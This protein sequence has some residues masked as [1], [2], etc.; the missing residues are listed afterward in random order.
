MQR[1]SLFL[2]LTLVV[3][4]LLNQACTP[5][6]S[7]E[8]TIREAGIPV[9]VMDLK[10][11]IWNPPIHTSGRFA[12]EDENVLAFKTG[13]II[14]NIYVRE[15]EAIKRGQ[16]LAKLNLTEISALTSQAE[17][18]FEK[19][20]R[21]Y[22][23]AE[24]LFAD[25]VA[26]LEQLQNSRTALDIA[27]QQLEQANFN[28]SHSEIRAP[29][30][31]YVLQKM[32]SSGQVMAGGMPVL[33]TSGGANTDWVLKT[34]LSDK[35]WAQIQVGDS[36]EILSTSLSEN[37]IKS[38]VLRKSKAA[39][40]MSGSFVVELAVPDPGQNLASGMFGKAT[41]FPTSNVQSW[42]IPYSA[43]LDA[44]AGKGY[45]FVT[46][47][48]STAEKIEVEIGSIANDHVQIIR[49]LESKSKLIVSGSPYLTDGSAITIIK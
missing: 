48:D 40:A 42:S 19:A 47:N 14:E 18:G 8:T 31:G 36:A 16:L 33:L 35:A 23:R 26:T 38:K 27:T 10:T 17:Y 24:K 5:A 3:I 12:S 9:R 20:K 13:G 7:A 49:G 37:P 34:G 46:T 30:D 39:Q 15:G 45:V 28:K 21:D 4:G 25:S 22:E 6:E 32:A 43:L 29:A 44:N 1:K 11:E 41:I 2:S